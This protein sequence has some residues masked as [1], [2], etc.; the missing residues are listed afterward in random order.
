MRQAILRKWQDFHVARMRYLRVRME[1]R[2]LDAEVRDEEV[3]HGL[4]VPSLPHTAGT[5]LG[6]E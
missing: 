5:Y 1:V 6:D 4:E 3:A 2:Q